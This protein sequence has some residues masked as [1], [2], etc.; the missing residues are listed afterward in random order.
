M[1]DPILSKAKSWI[2]VMLKNA[3]LQHEFFSSMFIVHEIFSFSL[4][5]AFEYKN[6]T[7]R[8]SHV[9]GILKFK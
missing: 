4:I 3:A 6:V 8:T 5:L 2:D 1:F 7:T 9:S